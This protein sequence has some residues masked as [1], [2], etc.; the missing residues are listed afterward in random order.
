MRGCYQ[1]NK[2]NEVKF[3]GYLETREMGN[4][5]FELISDFEVNIMINGNWFRCLVPKGFLTDF[6][7]VPRAP[8]AYTLFGGKYNRSGVIHDA[9]YSTW[10]EIKLFNITTGIELEADK[11]MADNILRKALISE[12]AN[13]LTAYLMYQGVNLFGGLYFKKSKV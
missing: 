4:K 8:L 13:S 11:S 1:M 10:H 5:V 3:I 2:I 7:S 6:T 12:G 9:L